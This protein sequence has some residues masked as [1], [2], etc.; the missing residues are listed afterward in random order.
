[1]LNGKVTKFEL[2]SLSCCGGGGAHFE[3]IKEFSVVLLSKVYF[4]LGIKR[5]ITL[6][7]I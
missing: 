3:K 4:D 5:H 2:F 6:L 1:M 7:G